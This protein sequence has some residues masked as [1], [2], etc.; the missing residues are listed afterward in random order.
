[1]EALKIYVDSNIFLNVWFEEMLRFSPAFYHSRKLLDAILEC[2]FRLVIS[3]LTVK[4]LSR[5]TNLS[6]EIIMKEYLRPYDMVEKLTVIETTKDMIR[7]AGS[8]S[9]KY[10]LHASDALHALVAK[11][12]GCI[13][14]TRDK[15]LRATARRIGLRAVLPEELI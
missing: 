9:R 3:D 8:I 14:V 7:E 13:L 6:K 4:E 1:L 2:K 5:K 10:R 15:E 12:E 11:N